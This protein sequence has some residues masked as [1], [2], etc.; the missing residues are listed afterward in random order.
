MVLCKS[1]LENVQLYMKLHFWI[2]FKDIVSI[3]FK[4]PIVSI[5]LS[6][7]FGHNWDSFADISF[8]TGS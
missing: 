4:V 5:L 2:L 6:M 7:E 1:T 3:F 8:S